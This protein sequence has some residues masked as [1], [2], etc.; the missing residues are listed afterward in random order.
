MLL[1]ILIL[2]AVSG[3]LLTLLIKL[4]KKPIKWIFKLLLHALFGYIFLFI[5]NFAGAWFGVSLELNWLNAIVSG[6][7]G[8]PG[9][10]VLLVLK[11]IL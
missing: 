10:V 7:F 3:G 11:Y 1:L 9:V 8:I 4:L 5:F 2:L 6:V